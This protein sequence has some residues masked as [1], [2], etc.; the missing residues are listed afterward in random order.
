MATYLVNLILEFQN[1]IE[2]NNI[3][4]KFFRI[5]LQFIST[6]CMNKKIIIFCSDSAHA[7]FVRATYLVCHR[8]KHFIE[9][10]F[11]FK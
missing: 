6:T 1:M 2:V 7:L 8:N 4:M 3:L 11:F 9:L 10:N 5:S